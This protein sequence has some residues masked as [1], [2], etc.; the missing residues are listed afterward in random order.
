[1][2]YLPSF[3]SQLLVLSAL[4]RSLPDCSFSLDDA[5]DDALCACTTPPPQV[6]GPRQRFDSRMGRGSALRG[7]VS[8]LNSERIN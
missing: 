1:M 3:S 5:L 4:F 2:T 7:V 8:S 6:F